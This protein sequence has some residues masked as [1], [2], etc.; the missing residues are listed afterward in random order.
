MIATRREPLWFR[1]GFGPGE[2]V[3]VNVARDQAFSC[4][5]VVGGCEERELKLTPGTGSSTHPFWTDDSYSVRFAHS[6]P[7]LFDPA[8]P[9][10]PEGRSH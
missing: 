8:H 3:F 5:L 4:M 9:E 2:I 7:A 1:Y 10:N 6:G